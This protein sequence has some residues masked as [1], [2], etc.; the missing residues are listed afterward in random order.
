MFKNLMFK[1]LVRSASGLPCRVSYRFRFLTFRGTDGSKRRGCPPKRGFYY[2]VFSRLFIEDG[3]A[4]NG[5]HSVKKTV[6]G[7][8]GRPRA[9][10]QIGIDEPAGAIVPANKRHFPPPVIEIRGHFESDCVLIELQN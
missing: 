8:V 2:L 10:S 7:I 5:K 3:R 4:Y 6:N 1:S 9:H